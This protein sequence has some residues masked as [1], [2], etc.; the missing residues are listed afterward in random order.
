MGT[1]GISVQHVSVRQDNN[2]FSLGLQRLGA[3]HRPVYSYHGFDHV[4]TT[5]LLYGSKV[6]SFGNSDIIKKLQL[7]LSRMILGVNNRQN[8]Y[9]AVVN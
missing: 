9:D 5:V 8:V 7:T 6:C 1:E 4:P 3:S 2:L